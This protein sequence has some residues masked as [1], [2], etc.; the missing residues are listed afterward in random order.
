MGNWVFSLKVLI[1]KNK[2]EH[3]MT[4]IGSTEVKGQQARQGIKIQCQLNM[5]H[6]LCAI[7]TSQKWCFLQY[8]VVLV[9][10]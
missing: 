8:Y 7:N 3:S 4:H 2:R 10:Q 9:I 5:L 1:L 6:Y